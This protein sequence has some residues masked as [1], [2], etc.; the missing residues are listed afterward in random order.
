VRT[1][2]QQTQ[3]RQLLSRSVNAWSRD[4]PAVWDREFA[5]GPWLQLLFEANIRFVV[6]WKKCNKLLDSW[7]EARPAW[8]ITRGKR[9]WDYRHLRDT[10]RRTSQGRG[11]RALCDPSD[12]SAAAVAGS[13]A[14]RSPA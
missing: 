7:G 5:S 13:S 6:R 9:L 1:S 14:P 4:R 11:G 3:Q 2:D 8:E 10:Y 12:T